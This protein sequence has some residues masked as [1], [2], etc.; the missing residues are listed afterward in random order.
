MPVCD[1]YASD[2]HV[3]VTGRTLWWTVRHEVR[4]TVF[5]ER[6]DPMEGDRY[7]SDRLNK[8]MLMLLKLK[9]SKKV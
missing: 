8:L 9:C 6:P 1:C 7:I 4:V 3:R 2:L 5:D